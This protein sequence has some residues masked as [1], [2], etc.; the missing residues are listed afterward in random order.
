MKRL[1]YVIVAVVIVIIIARSVFFTVDE[2]QYAIVVRLGNPKKTI[3]TPGLKFKL[4]SPIETVIFL[5]KRLLVFDPPGSEFLT[6]DKKNIV[7]D[8]YLCWRIDDPLRFIRTVSTKSQ[9]EARLIDIISSELGVALGKYPL[10]SLISVNP[11]DVK[12]TQ[13]MDEVKRGCD[14]SARSD[15]GIRVVDVRLKRFNFPDQNKPSVFDRMMAERD[16]IAKKYRAEGEE[17][18]MKIAADTDKKEKLILS[19]AYMK[20]QVLKGEG[21]AE[22]AGIYARAYNKN[23]EFYRLLRTLEA[24]NKFMDA[25]TTVILSSDSELLNLLMKGD[26]QKEK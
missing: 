8:A 7:A 24:Y 19:D 17:Q 5:D 16:Q 11:E 18:A 2:T 13:M 26:K 9:A 23:P 15:Y 20:A 10:S 1:F 25:K 6:E 12:I 14:E 4:P 22:A 21:E 3:D